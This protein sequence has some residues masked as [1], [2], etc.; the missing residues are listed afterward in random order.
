M[1]QIINKIFLT[2]VLL[3]KV[4]NKIKNKKAKKRELTLD[5]LDKSFSYGEL[6]I[7]IMAK[8]KNKNKY[9]VSCL[10]S[11]DLKFFTW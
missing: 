2:R 7:E 1:M 11:S 6:K 9:I 10:K 5:S 3:D 4:V 8:V